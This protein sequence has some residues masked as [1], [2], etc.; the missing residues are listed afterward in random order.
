MNSTFE[1]ELKDTYQSFLNRYYFDRW[2]AYPP[3]KSDYQ[4]SLEMVL[5]PDCNLKCEYCYM[6][7]FGDRLY[8][9]EIRDTKTTL[10]NQKLLLEYLAKKG[11]LPHELEVF[12]G[13]RLSA[14]TYE[15]MFQTIYDIY[16]NADRRVSIILPLNAGFTHEQ[17]K[18]DVFLKWLDRFNNIESHVGIS[19]SMDGK[20]ADP[21]SR[22]TRDS[23]L[24]YDD[25]FYER[26]GEIAV[27]TDSNFH[28]MVSPENIHVWI[29]NFDWWMKYISRIYNISKVEALSR[30]YLLEVRNPNWTTLELGHL[31]DFIFHMTKRVFDIYGNNP[32]DFV[33]SFL[34]GKSLNFY[35]PVLSSIGRGIGC[36]IQSCFTVR[37]GDLTIIPCHRIAATGQESGKFIVQDGE[38]VDIEPMSF[39]IH[40]AI[41][42]FKAENAFVCSHCPINSM[43]AFY[44]LGANFEFNNSLFIPVPT[45]CRMEHFKLKAMFK[46]FEHLGIWNEYERFLQ[47]QEYRVAISKL[48]QAKY[49][50][51]A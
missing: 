46:S 36:S 8:P 1:K 49:I 34:T 17:K 28:P 20:Y 41:N 19:F 48:E 6:N 14:D 16:F 3:V 25:A 45:V 26:A 51:G 21:I 18:L 31:T 42:S 7:K 9:K 24:K 12:A 32:A 29:D 39:Y 22:P 15:Q 38:I 35:H 30:L 11:T 13:G 4:T 50:K 23:K 2:K 33:R 43:C 27:M 10:D 5:S 37:L 44:C 47:G 40:L